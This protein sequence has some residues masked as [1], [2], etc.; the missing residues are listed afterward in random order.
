MEQLL[1]IAPLFQGLTQNDL[2]PIA[3]ASRKVFCAAGQQLFIEGDPAI[4]FFLVLKGSVRLYRLT[5]DGK[6]KVI[7]IIR[8]GETFAESVALLDRPYPVCASAIETLEMIAIPAE[9]IKAQVK[10]NTG[11]ALKMLASLSMRVHRFVNDIHALSMS[12]AQQ[13]VA[14]Y[15]LAFLSEDM[16][17]QCIQLPSTKALVAARLGLQPET[18]SRVLGRMK[19]QGVIREENAQ[20]IVLAPEKLRQLR[21]E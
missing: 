3:N 19:D 18:F 10:Q 17:E 8:T 7:E 6:E 21:D 16:G 1:R 15:F 14:G 2:L 9:V 20:V 4:Q 11:L 5:H 13:K 12:T